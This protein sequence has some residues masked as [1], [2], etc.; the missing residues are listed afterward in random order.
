M[1]NVFELWHVH[2]TY[3]GT[4]RFVCKYAFQLLIANNNVHA[5]YIVMY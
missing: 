4:G 1:C 3:L 2:T 5:C